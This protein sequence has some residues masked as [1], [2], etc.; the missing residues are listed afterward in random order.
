[1]TT[2]GFVYF[3]RA[4]NAVKIGHTVDLKGRQHNL[5]T[6]C[7]ESGFIARYVKGSRRDERKMHERFS[8]Y[9]L[10]GE[11]FDL[12]G[13]LAKYL[14][15]HIRPIDLPGRVEIAR[16]EVDEPEFYL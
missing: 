7:P 1:M 4:G 14:E 6:A 13:R 10:R 12:R 8:E 16:I 5:L 3:F 11:W 15:M 9:H 2:Q